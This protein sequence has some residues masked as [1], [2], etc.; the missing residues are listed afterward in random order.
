MALRQAGLI[1]RAEVAANLVITPRAGESFR[2]RRIFTANHSG[3]L[4]HLTVINDTARV[5]FFRLVGLGGAHLFNPRETEHPQATK[6]S[7]VLDWMAQYN[8]FQG[9]PVVQGESLTLSLDTGTADIFAV[10]DSYDVG[11]VKSTEMNGSKSADI[12]YM[13]YG[14]NLAAIVA[15]GYNKVNSSRNPAEMPSFPFGAP[16]QGLVPAGKKAQITLIGGQAVGRFVGAGATA[17]TQYIRPRIGSAPAQ[18]IL[19]RNDVGVQ[20]FGTIPGAGVD[21]TSLRQAI[22]STPSAFETT[23]AVLPQLDFNGNDELS[24]Q[25]QTTI[26]GAGQL[27]AADI[28]LWCLQRIFPA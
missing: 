23:D 4:Q 8:G 14:T 9:Y 3:A 12:L 22:S 28:D 24:L 26:V 16:G 11:D 18:T 5:G 2:V 15:T 25:V 17:Q 6:G 13:N 1:F 20:F 27:N 19:D 7:N 21:Y 10:A